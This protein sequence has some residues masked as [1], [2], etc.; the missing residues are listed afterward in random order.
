VL[1]EARSA[2]TSVVPAS[3]PLAPL[4]ALLLWWLPFPD[5]GTN[6]HHL[7]Q[8]R[9]HLSA[10]HGLNVEEM[11]VV[12]GGEV[13]LAKPNPLEEKERTMQQSELRAVAEAEERKQ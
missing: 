6:Y 3:V 10:R 5:A 12:R 1:A 9:E 2:S 13:R 8:I 4:W 7:A 11:V